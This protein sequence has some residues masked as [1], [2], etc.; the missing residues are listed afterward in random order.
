MSAQ[1]SYSVL[2]RVFI[3]AKTISKV[4]KISLH[5][6]HQKQVLRILWSILLQKNTQQDFKTRCHDLIR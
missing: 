2:C 5:K 3:V 4:P 6:T 1:K